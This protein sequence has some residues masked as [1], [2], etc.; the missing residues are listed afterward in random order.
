MT[1]FYNK[2][3]YPP[4]ITDLEQYRK[5]GQDKYRRRADYHLLWPGTAYREGQDILIAGCGTSQAAKG[6]SIAQGPL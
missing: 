4:P 3:P 5:L 2:H 6:A 1:T